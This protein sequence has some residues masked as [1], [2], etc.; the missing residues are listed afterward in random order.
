[1][2]EEIEKEEDGMTMEF[3]AQL[4]SSLLRG[5]SLEREGKKNQ[6]LGLVIRD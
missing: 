5:C 6:I 2:D 3:L 4:F 1:M